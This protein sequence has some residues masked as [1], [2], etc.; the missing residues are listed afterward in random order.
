MVRLADL[1]DSDRDNMLKKIPTLPNFAG[2]PWVKGVPLK[3]RRVAVVTT[4]GLHT[5]GDRP[6]GSGAMDYR[7]IPGNTQAN[8]LVMS[9][10]SVN[11]DRVGF[12]QDWNVAFPLDRLRE[13]ARD[14]AIGSVANY[15]YSFMGAVSPVTNYEA[16]AKELAQHLHADKVDAV[17]LTP[18]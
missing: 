16:K 10:M 3:R 6:F 9:H 7:V 14:G 13:L 15:H 18:V 8:D 11:F 5:R 17:L 1:S 2:R 12:Q 4:A